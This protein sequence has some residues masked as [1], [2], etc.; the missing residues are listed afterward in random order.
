MQLYHDGVLRVT[1]EGV[2]N[3]ELITRFIEEHTGAPEPSFSVP[4]P[5]VPEHALQTSHNERNPH[6]EVLALT[7]ESFAGVVAGGDVFVKFFAPWWV[8]HF[9]AQSRR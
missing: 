3:Y 6:G 4:P 1:F 5:E 7:P 9:L 2:R 8:F